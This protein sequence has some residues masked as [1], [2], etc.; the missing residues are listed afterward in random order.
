[1]LSAGTEDQ[2][3]RR[4]V[5]CWSSSNLLPEFATFAGLELP[6]M[7]V[8]RR[9]E[10]RGALGHARDVGVLAAGVRVAVDGA[11]PVEGGYPERGGQ[12]AVRPAA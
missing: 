7:R 1:V 12:V 10:Q 2:F 8:I 6:R 9:R 3:R 11:E 4:R 5:A